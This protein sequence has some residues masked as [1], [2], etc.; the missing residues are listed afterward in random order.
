MKKSLAVLLVSSIMMM[1]ETVCLPGQTC[2]SSSSSA[3]GSSIEENCLPGVVDCSSSSSSS[4]SCDIVVWD[5]DDYFRNPH[6]LPGGDC[7][8]IYLTKSSVNVIVDR[9]KREERQKFGS[10]EDYFNGDK[11]YFDRATVEAIIERCRTNP[12]LCGIN[13]VPIKTYKTPRQE[14][15]NALADRE[16]PIS[17]YYLHYSNGMFDWVYVSP[18]KN[19]YKLEQGIGDDYVLQWSIVQSGNDKAFSDITIKDG[20]IKFGKSLLP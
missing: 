8:H 16:I 9:C 6:C 20:Y 7:D 14:V 13:A 11:E 4:S 3:S 5:V 1:A 15:V 12:Q 19:V 17:G 18:Q 2:E 10:V